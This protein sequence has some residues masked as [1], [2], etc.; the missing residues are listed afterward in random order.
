[1]TFFK[2]DPK[3]NLSKSNQR[4]NHMSAAEILLELPKLKPEEQK[5]IWNSL[6]DLM[7]PECDFEDD[8]EDLSTRNARSNHDSNRTAGNFGN[9]VGSANA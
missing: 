8:D 3:L 4:M 9:P 6:N 5:E 1:M 7:Y 2:N